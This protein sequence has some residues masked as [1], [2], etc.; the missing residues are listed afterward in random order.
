M[1]LNQIGD[2]IMMREY[3]AVLNDLAKTYI[4][5][6]DAEIKNP[7]NLLNIE[8]LKGYYEYKG[9]IESLKEIKKRA[10]ELRE[11][12]I[13]PAVVYKDDPIVNT[14]VNKFLDRSKQGMKKYG[15]SMHDNNKPVA[16]WI[17][18]AQEELM[19]GI[20]YL[21]K[22]K[23]KVKDIKEQTNFMWGKL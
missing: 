20:L 6:E 10:Q 2:N 11:R 13:F 16:D 8:P 21:Q 3:T 19:D 15:T 5:L 12:A 1:K 9:I 23:E 18:D 7:C 17:E 22:L 14:V 4:L